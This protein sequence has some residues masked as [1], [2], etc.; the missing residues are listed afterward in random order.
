M[1][2][3]TTLALL[4]GWICFVSAPDPDLHGADIPPSGAIAGRVQLSTGQYLSNATV[5]V[6]GSNASIPTDRFGFYRLNNVPS[7]PIVIQVTYT[8]Q[9]TSEV[10]LN[11]PAGGSLTHDVTL[12]PVGSNIVTMQ[13]FNVNEREAIA[14]EIATHEQRSAPNIKNVIATD[15]F[16]DITG[17]NLGDFLQYVPGLTVEYSDI[18]V[19]GV[20]ARGFGSALTNYSSDGAPLA[21]GDL[22][23]T[24]RTR[25]NHL[26]LNN[27]A[28]IEVTKV[29]TP[30]NPADSMGGSVNLV[31]KSAF[32]SSAGTR[33]NW[34]L[35]LFGNSKALGVSKEPN[36][37][38][39]EEYLI[40][41][42][43]TFDATWAV[44]K[45][46]GV[47]VSADSA[48]QYNEQFIAS[49]TWNAGGTSTGASFANPYFQ[50]FQFTNNPRD[51]R[52]RS[53][54]FKV[55]W[56]VTPNSVLS[57]GG[58][59]NTL[60]VHIA[61]N[62]ITRNVG[63]NGTPTPATG[64][65][66][67][68]GSDFTNGA[69]GRGS[70]GI[71]GG[72]QKQQ[73]VAAGGN[74]RYRFD[75]GDWNAQVG[76][77]LNKTRRFDYDAPAD[78]MFNGTTIALRTPV[79]I[80]FGA[81]KPDGPGTTRAFDNN[82][83]EVDL[84][85]LNNYIMTGGT[86]SGYFYRTGV[87]SLDLSARRNLGWFSF[88]AT[89]QVGG[90]WSHQWMNGR[91]H[92]KTYTYNGPDGNPAT[93]DSPA[94][95]HS[96][97][98]M[99]RANPFGIANNIPWVGVKSMYAAWEANPNLFTQTL[100]QQVSAET[101]RIQN[102]LYIDETITAGY[103]Q[104]EIKLLNNR[105]NVLT[106]VRYERTVDDGMGPL[107]DPNAVYVRNANGTLARTAAGTLIRKPEAGAVGSM[108]QLRFVWQ[109][110]AAH[111]RGVF[112][113]YFPSMHLTYNITDNFLARAA[114]A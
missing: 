89:L 25:L 111:G 13:R 11:V 5:A 73:G 29:P 102:S 100:A 39:R 67:T 1:K 81:I 75:N 19:A 41:P 38:D 12:N 58:Q 113:D 76:L 77:S 69:T 49:T 32:D 103:I 47:V 79:R 20:S 27:L 63:T 15:A 78:R 24:R 88:P 91:R 98:F 10:A 101:S 17:G 74:V 85:N 18:E 30:A 64:V 53:L 21:G 56:R 96:R 110:R 54:T 6:K 43:F 42:G 109:E 28:R 57:F 108:E 52:R 9:E 94:P 60:V 3:K 16:G 87:E 72:S 31:S 14:E 93:P 59:G 66:M 51:K 45:N 106:G 82:N 107:N 2:R 7:G 35:N 68:F 92:N 104:G 36:G 44:N 86:D 70:A 90:M 37:F 40:Y 62:N 99:T 48:H 80:S 71:N 34:G 61:G 65:P 50:N 55:D 114:Y 26:G 8:G 22:S 112:T 23:A 84:Y 95:Y 46:L 105:L 83:Q 33:V 4:I 97:I